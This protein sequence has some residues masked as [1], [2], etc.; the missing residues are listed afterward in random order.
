[1]AKYE[2]SLKE[3]HGAKLDLHE[4]MEDGTIVLLAGEVYSSDSK[5]DYT[6]FRKSSAI[7]AKV[8]RA[9]V[10]E[11]AAPVVVDETPANDKAAKPVKTKEDTKE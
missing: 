10:V 6:R 1:M 11:P 4:P 7:E 2:F 8:N 9:P 3:G 5:A